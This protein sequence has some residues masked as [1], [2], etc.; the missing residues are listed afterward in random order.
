LTFHGDI[1][2]LHCERQRIFMAPLCA[3]QL[4][5]FYFDADPDSDPAAELM[6]IH[7]RLPKLIR[8]F[9]DPDQIQMRNTLC[10]YV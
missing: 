1:L 4:L 6:Q 7:I 2:S 10:P 8:I 5:N 3:T 9:A